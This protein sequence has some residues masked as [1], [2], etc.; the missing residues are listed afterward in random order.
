[1]VKTPCVPNQGS[2]LLYALRSEIKQ[3][4]NDELEQGDGGRLPS[5][6]QWNEQGELQSNN[7]Q[8]HNFIVMEP[9]T[10]HIL[11]VVAMTLAHSS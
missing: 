9:K 10:P 7:N 11:L 5:R 2:F 6:E 8:H 1:M 4:N 3:D